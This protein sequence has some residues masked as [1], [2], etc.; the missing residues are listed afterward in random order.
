MDSWKTV[1]PAQFY[2]WETKEICF[3][4][5]AFKFKFYFLFHWEANF[6]DNTGFV[7][8]PS[9]FEVKVLIFVCGFALLV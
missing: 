5:Y 4:K 3:T 7:G 6:M 2:C 9:I 1:Y 8:C